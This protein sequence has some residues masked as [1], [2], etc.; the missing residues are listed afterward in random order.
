MFG[1]EE[2]QQL[3]ES[4]GNMSDEEL[5]KMTTGD[6]NHYRDEALAIAVAELTGRGFSVEPYDGKE[7]GSEEISGDVVKYEMI[8]GPS[9][10]RATLLSRAAQVA[11]RL[12]DRNVINI[13]HSV[14][15]HEDVIVIWYWYSK[16][17]EGRTEDDA[18]RYK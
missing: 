11:T 14:S 18:W 2:L 15:G 9:I 6:A 10:D 13:S 7:E 5:I 8:K 16:D 17:G 1:D 3:R 12:G 4:I